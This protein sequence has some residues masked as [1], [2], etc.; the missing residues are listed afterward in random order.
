MESEG[1]NQERAVLPSHRIVVAGIGPGNPHYMVPAARA[2]IEEAR[3]LVGGRRALAQ[4][5]RPAGSGQETMAVTRDIAGV[6][7]FIKSHLA[8][9][10]VVVMVSGDP[11]YYSLLD[12][13][14]R[15]F[16][17][18]CLKV[19]PGISAMQLAFARLALPWHE[20][21]LLSFHGRRPQDA[22]LAYRPGRIL[23]LL[24]D[25]HYT[26]H[27]IPAILLA[28]DWP[29]DT[30]LYICARLSYEDEAV[31]ATTL[32]EAASLPEVASSVLVV[33]APEPQESTSPKA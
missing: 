1:L 15:C 3:V 29:A 21:T 11:G 30:G 23:G 16:P 9:S 18:A 28:A 4:F 12:A 24:T 25:A 5:A 6:M 31:T 26:S 10:D 14:R 17:P 13:L 7:A 19:I 32:G 22:P 8:A 20:A 27:T 2:A 33:V